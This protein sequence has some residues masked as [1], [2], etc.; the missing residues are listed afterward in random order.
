MR[1]TGEVISSFRG[2]P[3][4]NCHSVTPYKNVGA[5]TDN[6]IYHLEQAVALDDENKLVLAD[7]H[8]EMA[9]AEDLPLGDSFCRS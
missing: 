8:F 1:V 6:A 7:E 9:L 4:I 2:Q 3:W 5:F